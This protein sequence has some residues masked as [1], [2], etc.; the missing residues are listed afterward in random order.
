MCITRE[1]AETLHYGDHVHV[2]ECSITIGPRGGVK[3]HRVAV[4]INGKPKFWK[5]RPNDF[6][7]P[8]KYGLYEYG[9]INQDNAKDFH[10]WQ[11]CP[12]HQKGE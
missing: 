1:Q 8:Y 9:Y 6:R 2:G 3:I 4:K 10:I 5:R 11:D 7:I 12:L